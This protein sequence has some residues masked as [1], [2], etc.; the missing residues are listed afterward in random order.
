MSSHGIDTSYSGYAKPKQSVGTAH[1]D[2][3][4]TNLKK[5]KFNDFAIHN[6]GN[7]LNGSVNATAYNN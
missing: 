3:E 1:F 5:T 6:I 4:N 2:T 7:F